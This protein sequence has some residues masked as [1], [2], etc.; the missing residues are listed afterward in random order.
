MEVG[1]G[2]MYGCVNVTVLTD[3]LGIQVS[4]AYQ[5][6][7][8]LGL[9]ETLEVRTIINHIVYGLTRVLIRVEIIMV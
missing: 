4:F 6:V 9:L 7:E 5:P 1:A 8:S 3:P 2:R